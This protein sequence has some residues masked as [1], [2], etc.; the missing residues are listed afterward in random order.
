MPDPSKRHAA[1][2]ID[3]IEDNTAHLENLNPEHT[4]PQSITLPRAWLPAEAREGTALQALF[5]LEAGPNQSIVSFMVDEELTRK[6]KNDMTDL[7]SKIPKAP[8]G[9]FKL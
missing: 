3:R 7:R 2:I 9:D 1:Y 4:Q 8:K 6:R 5:Q